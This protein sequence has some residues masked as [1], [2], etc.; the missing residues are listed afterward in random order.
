MTLA[1]GSPKIRLI[2]LEIF[3]YEVIGVFVIPPPP[4]QSTPLTERQLGEQAAGECDSGYGC[5]DKSVFPPDLHPVG[6]GVLEKVDRLPSFPARVSYN[7]EGE[8]QN[9]E[10]DVVANASYNRTLRWGFVWVSIG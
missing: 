3:D 5:D 7:E 8:M 1:C 10:N 2:D 4:Q 9:V 6:M